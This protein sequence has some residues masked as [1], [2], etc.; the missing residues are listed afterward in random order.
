[1][2]ACHIPA[3]F[4]AAEKGVDWQAIADIGDRLKNTRDRIE[5]HVLW[6]MSQDKLVPFKACAERHLVS[7]G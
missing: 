3:T 2:A 4:K 1:M 6:T 7:P 5:T